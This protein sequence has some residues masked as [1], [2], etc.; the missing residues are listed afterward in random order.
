MNHALPR[1]LPS[2]KAMGKNAESLIMKTISKIFRNIFQKLISV[3]TCRYLSITA[4]YTEQ[5]EKWWKDPENV[6]LCQFMAK[7]NVPFHTV[8][9]P[10]TLIGT[11]EPYSMLNNISATGEVTSLFL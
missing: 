11:R 1:Y 2:M 10:A 7:D 6:S 3:T 9:F 4:N 5:W 8:V